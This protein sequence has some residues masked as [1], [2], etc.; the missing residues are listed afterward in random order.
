METPGGR[1]PWTRFIAQLYFVFKRNK[2]T[3]K[4]G[5]H[6]LKGCVM[7]VVVMGF[8]ILVHYFYCE[9]PRWGLSQEF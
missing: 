1:T 9:P 3:W 7:V 6:Q 5:G 4:G 8:N 2:H